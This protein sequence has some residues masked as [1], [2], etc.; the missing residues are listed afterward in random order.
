MVGLFFCTLP[1]ADFANNYEGPIRWCVLDLVLRDCSVLRKLVSKFFFVHKRK[2]GARFTTVSNILNKVQT[3]YYNGGYSDSEEESEEEE[4]RQNIKEFQE[5]F[6][7]MTKRS[8]LP[9][10]PLLKEKPPDKLPTEESPTRDSLVS[11]VFYL[12][13]KN[14]ALGSEK[15]FSGTEE[16][17]MLGK[18]N[19]EVINAIKNMKLIGVASDAEHLKDKAPGAGDSLEHAKEEA[20]KM[21]PENSL[22]RTN[23][24]YLIFDESDV[25]KERKRLAKYMHGPSILLAR[26]KQEYYKILSFRKHKI[27][28]MK[29]INSIEEGYDSTDNYFNSVEKFKA[30]F[31][32][33]SQSV[34]RQFVRFFYFEE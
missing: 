26:N 5:N 31:E 22:L 20:V 16:K 6:H 24:Y 27:F 30:R 21:E 7:S 15:I 17:P 25:E 2:K 10:I 33:P 1:D 18:S 11:S 34:M 14:E 9:S 13:S 4:A 29:T 23:R 8:K 19:L 12:T 28:N 32:N 3:S